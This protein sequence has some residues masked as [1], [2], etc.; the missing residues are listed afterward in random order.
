[1]T[2]DE[3][4]R[5]IEGQARLNQVGNITS[6][7]LNIYFERAQLEV[8]DELRKVFEE[9]SIIS[10]ELSPILE[11]I[12]ITQ[13]SS[14]VASKPS[15]YR[16]LIPPLEAD[17]Y[18]NA[19]STVVAYQ[20]WVPVIFVTHGEK[21]IRL[22]SQIDYPTA[23]DPIAVNYDTYFQIYPDTLQKVRL[24]YIRKP[25]TPNWAYT[26]VNSGQVYNAGSS[27]G[28]ELPDSTHMR[29]CL[30]VLGYYGISLRDQELF[31]SSEGKLNKA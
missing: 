27:Q 26:T 6:A 21:S 4:K 12:D 2:I 8:V 17:Y 9:S 22:N 14:G 24:T 19:T 7:Q 29:I 15:N 25:L 3:A 1:M 11:T 18:T 31:G 30:K 28:F 13:I 10:D 23:I 16:F 20:S 5:F